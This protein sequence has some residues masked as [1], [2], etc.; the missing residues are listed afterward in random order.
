MDSSQTNRWID[1]NPTGPVGFRINQIHCVASSRM[2]GL[3]DELL[4][5]DYRPLPHAIYLKAT[6]TNIHLML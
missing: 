2:S 1:L 6:Q 3:L 5:R 4:G